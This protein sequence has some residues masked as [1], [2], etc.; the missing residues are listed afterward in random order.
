MADA[1]LQGK[2]VLVTGATGGIGKVAAIE[3]AKLGPELVIVGRDPKRTADAVTEIQSKS[4]NNNV[5]A[6]ITI[7][8]G[9]TARPNRDIIELLR[10]GASPRQPRL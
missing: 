8:N 1:G 7:A 10:R 9:R 6:L 4:G 2:V 5:S 3:L